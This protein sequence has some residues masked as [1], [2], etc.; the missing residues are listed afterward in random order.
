MIRVIHDPELEKHS[1]EGDNSLSVTPKDVSK[2]SASAK[3]V[4]ARNVGSSDPDEKQQELLDEVI[5]QSFPASD[6]PASG[7]VT[8]IEVPSTPPSK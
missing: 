8:R 5:E 4:T 1:S 6:P 3:D 2:K 7:G